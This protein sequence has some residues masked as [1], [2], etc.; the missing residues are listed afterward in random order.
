MGNEKAYAQYNDNSY[1][2]LKH[3][4]L[5]ARSSSVTKDRSAQSKGI[6]RAIEVRLAT[7]DF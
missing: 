5:P 3:K 2:S 4:Q 7:E 1:D 6:H